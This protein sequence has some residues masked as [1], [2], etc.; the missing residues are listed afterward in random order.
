MLQP[1]DARNW[2]TLTAAHLLNR[3][4]FGGAPAEIAALHDAGFPAAVDQLLNGPDDS[5]QHPKPAWAVPVNRVEMRQSMRDASEEQRRTMMA[6]ARGNER[7][8]LLDLT[9]GWL[10]RMRKTRNPLREKMT[11]FWHGHFATSVEKVRQAYLMW[12]QN[13]TLRHHALGNFGDLTKAVSRDPAMM[14]YL[15]TARSRKSHPNENY[16]RELMELFTLG[17]GNYTEE[18]I[19]EAARA[20]TG[21]VINRRTQESMFAARGHDNGEKTFLGRTANYDA[22]GI[23]D[24][25]LEQPA[26][27][28]FIARKLW[29]YFAYENPEPKMVESLA[30][31]LRNNRYEIRPVLGEL[32]RSAAFYSPRAI[33]TQIKSPIQWVVQTSKI[34]ESPLPPGRLLMGALRQLGQVPFAPPSVK[35]WDGGKA[36]ITTS[37]LLLRYNL[38]NMILGNGPIPGGLGPTGRNAQV[39]PNRARAEERLRRVLQSRVDLAKIAPKDLREDRDQLVEAMVM[40]LFQD[41]LTPRETAAFSRFLESKQPDNSDAVL[42]ELLHLMMSTPQ[43]QLT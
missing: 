13:E 35:G 27:A 6:E 43:Y 23:V 20:F 3:A 17:I 5:P 16:A 8:N 40:R 29:T 9:T 37:T 19:K 34:L 24:R 31:S 21:Y 30:G 2:N 11:L 39:R 18:D 41:P 14:I 28:T 12:M 42:R 10:E 1:F 15:D 22:E 25:I 32:F 26:C 38:A 7:E 4:G 36:W 33:R